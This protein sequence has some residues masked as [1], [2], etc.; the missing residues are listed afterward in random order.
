MLQKTVTKFNNG[1]IKFINQALFVEVLSVEV[2]PV[3]ALPA[4]VY[5]PERAANTALITNID[6]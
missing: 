1:V 5:Q 2:L 4:G 3:K 6:V